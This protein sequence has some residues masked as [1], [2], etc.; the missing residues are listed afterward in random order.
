MIRR[1]FSKIQKNRFFDPKIFVTNILQPRKYRFGCKTAQKII[2]I[3]FYACKPFP[4]KILVDNSPSIIFQL[5]ICI[6]TSKTQKPIFSL[7]YR[8]RYKKTSKNE[9]FLNF[10]NLETFSFLSIYTFIGVSP[11]V[12]KIYAF[13]FL[14]I[15]CSRPLAGSFM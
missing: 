15:V 5:K 1:H 7:K 11:I 10:Q 13:I 2:K 6:P 8:F 14:P 12:K 9:K 3:W 4:N